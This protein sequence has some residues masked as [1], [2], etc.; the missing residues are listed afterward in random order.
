MSLFGSLFMN[1]D[2]P[3]GKYTRSWLKNSSEEELNSE[4]EEIRQRHCSGD[5]R[6]MGFLDMIDREKDERYEATHPNSEHG[7]PVHR[8]HGW[9]LPNDE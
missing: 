1:S 4:R 3:Y 7:Y 6:A 9:Y 8:E 5:E 2:D